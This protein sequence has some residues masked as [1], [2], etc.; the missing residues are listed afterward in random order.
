M[1]ANRRSDAFGWVGSLILGSGVLAI[2]ALFRFDSN[3][4]ALY[5]VPIWFAAHYSG[6][7]ACIATV[8]VVTSLSLI[9]VQGDA[10]TILIKSFFRGSTLAIIA[11][12]ILKFESL[13]HDS[14]TQSRVDPLT[15]V[16]NRRALAEAWE[17]SK[18]L[19]ETHEAYFPCSVVMI[20]CND[21]KKLNDQHGH[22]SGDRVSRMLAEALCSQIRGSDYVARLGGDEFVV[23]LRGTSEEDA[24]RIFHRI[25]YRFESMARDA[26]FDCSISIGISTLTHNQI[27]LD[28]AIRDADQAMY[29]NKRFRQNEV[30]FGK[31]LSRLSCLIA[32]ASYLHSGRPR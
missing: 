6:R 10:A 4:V 18:R 28:Q 27:A 5:I 17:L 19:P 16:L 2:H 15:G 11:W 21:F 20:D 22:E 25:S 7:T 1:L 13:L 26:G 12:L 30:A 32:P 3:L 29:L 24:R 9:T 8:L 23:V 31:A 14:R